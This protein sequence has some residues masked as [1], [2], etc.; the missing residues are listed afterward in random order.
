MTADQNVAEFLKKK[1][2]DNFILKG[3]GVGGQK[4]VEIHL[5]KLGFK[6]KR[7]FPI[8]HSKMKVMVQVVIRD[9]LSESVFSK[10]YALEIKNK[11]FISSLKFVDAQVINSLLQEMVQDILMDDELLNELAY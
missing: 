1:L 4:M 10:D 6:A 11:Y 8:G 3:F 5:Q 7:G 9:T 2:I